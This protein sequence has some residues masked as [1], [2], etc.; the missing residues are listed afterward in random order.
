MTMT[1]IVII[2][3]LFNII[4]LGLY[5]CQCLPKGLQGISANDVASKEGIAVTRVWSES[6]LQYG[7]VTDN[8]MCY[9]YGWVAKTTPLHI[10][11]A[12]VRLFP[13]VS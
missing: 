3:N 6:D 4:A 9:G 10:S 7:S 8:I 2:T 5:L 12:K 11:S 1:I 13:V